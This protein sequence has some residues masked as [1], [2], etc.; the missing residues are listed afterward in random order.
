MNRLE[1][2]LR[3]VL[4]KLDRRLSKAV[5]LDERRLVFPSMA[6]KDLSVVVISRFGSENVLLD[7]GQYVGSESRRGC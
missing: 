3:C 4:S 2:V 7:G 1:N 6:R 5:G